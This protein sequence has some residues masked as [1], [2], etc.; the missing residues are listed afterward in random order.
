MVAMGT[1]CPAT[2]FPADAFKSSVGHVATICCSCAV[3]SS[4]HHRMSDAEHS[5][6]TT[7]MSESSGSSTWRLH[8]R[9]YVLVLKLS[10]QGKQTACRRAA[11]GALQRSGQHLTLELC[12]AHLVMELRL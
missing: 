6:G 5:S 11:R 2:A 3:G 1:S 7:E 12:V 4:D 8:A 10:G 9:V